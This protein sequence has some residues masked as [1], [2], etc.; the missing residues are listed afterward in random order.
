MQESFRGGKEGGALFYHLRHCHVRSYAY[1]RPTEERDTC[2]SENKNMVEVT[3][4]ND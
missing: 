4:G 1:V 2:Y 3:F